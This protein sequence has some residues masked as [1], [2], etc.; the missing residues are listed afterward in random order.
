MKNQHVLFS[1]LSNTTDKF[2]NI[3]I[4][5]RFVKNWLY[6]NMKLISGKMIS[7]KGLRKKFIRPYNHVSRQLAVVSDLRH[8]HIRLFNSKLWRTQELIYCSLIFILYKEI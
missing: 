2:G 5:K 7:Y 3:G 1:L 8:K 6:Q 4:F